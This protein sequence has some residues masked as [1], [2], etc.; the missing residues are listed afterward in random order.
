[1]DKAIDS[2]PTYIDGF[3]SYFNR[4]MGTNH[5]QKVRPLFL[6]QS[7]GIFVTSE[8]WGWKTQE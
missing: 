3:Q 4:V 7:V 5:L 2:N 1:M 8:I 6:P